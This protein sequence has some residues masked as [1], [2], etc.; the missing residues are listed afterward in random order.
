MSRGDEIETLI[1]ERRELNKWMLEA[2]DAFT[3]IR[4]HALWA[5]KRYAEEHTSEN[6]EV[7]LA[8]QRINDEIAKVLPVL[9]SDDLK[10]PFYMSRL[11]GILRG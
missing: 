2:T 1:N 7:L 8:L 4:G 3:A 9:P 11:T 10:S 6:R 5:A